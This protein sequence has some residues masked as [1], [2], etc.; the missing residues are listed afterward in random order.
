MI[1]KHFRHKQC[2]IM[3]TNEN[4]EHKH[5]FVHILQK[6]KF[7]HPKGMLYLVMYPGVLTSFMLWIHTR[8]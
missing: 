2:L 7:S 1:I 4:F 3:K 6:D 5:K 8:P